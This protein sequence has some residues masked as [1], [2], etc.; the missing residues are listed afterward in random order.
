[1]GPGCGFDQDAIAGS[2]GMRLP[3]HSSASRQAGHG[4]LDDPATTQINLVNYVESSE[5]QLQVAYR[6]DSGIV[7]MVLF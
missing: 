1:M 4:G 5:E 2:V 3:D 7:E 6:V